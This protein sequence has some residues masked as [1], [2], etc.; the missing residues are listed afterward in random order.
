M[1][2][3]FIVQPEP[4]AKAHDDL[5]FPSL[6]SKAL[7][8]LG[9]F[10]PSIVNTTFS[11]SL[12]ALLTAMIVKRLLRHNHELRTLFND[13]IVANGVPY[14]S[15]TAMLVESSGLVVLASLAYILFQFIFT[16]VNL[17]FIV[18]YSQVSPFTRRL[19]PPPLARH[20]T[21]LCCGLLTF[22]P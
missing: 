22:I 18:V 17:Y 19:F 4:E 8:T 1:V 16:R 12:N 3:P 15:I 14:M 2:G 7:G 9:P 13:N 10:L 5:S 21:L 6:D 11:M 20:V